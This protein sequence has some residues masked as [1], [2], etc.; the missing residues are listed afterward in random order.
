MTGYM[1]F[2]KYSSKPVTDIFGGMT[3]YPEYRKA[4]LDKSSGVRIKKVTILELRERAYMSKR[5][6]TET[7]NK[8]RLALAREEMIKKLTTF[9]EKRKNE[10]LLKI[11]RQFFR[12]DIHSLAIASTIPTGPLNQKQEWVDCSICKG[13]GMFHTGQYG[14]WETCP[15]CKGEKKIKCT[16]PKPLSE[17]P[18]ASS[19]PNSPV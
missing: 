14:S 5:P 16:D 12:D 1:L 13:T 19:K 8:Y 15:T 3:F 2:Y 7:L 4:Y 17:Q 10:D 6:S 18:I 9:I 11:Y